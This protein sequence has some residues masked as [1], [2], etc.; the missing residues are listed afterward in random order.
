MIQNS[1]GIPPDQQ[2]LIFAGMQLEDGRLLSD[3]NIQPE[4]TLHLVLRLRG[5]GWGVLIRMPDGKNISVSCPP[6][7]Y[8]IGQ[9]YLQVF[10][11]YPTIK[12]EKIVLFNQG[13]RLEPKKTIADYAITPQNYEIDA[14]I[15]SYYFGSQGIIKE[16]KVSGYWELNEDM[17]VGL[18]ILTAYQTA[19]PKYNSNPRAAMTAVIIEYLEATF[20]EE[21]EELKLIIQ[22]AKRY[23]K[24]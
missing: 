16:M 21:Q 23:L 12:R 18:E 13:I 24:K 4:S 3:Y 9:L 22:K 11:S 10:K 19:L 2:R 20:P 14:E 7:T 1:E 17:L 5:G 6:P 15:P 8:F